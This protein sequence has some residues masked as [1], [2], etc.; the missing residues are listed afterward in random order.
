SERKKLT[1]T[2]Q[3]SYPRR[4][5]RTSDQ[6]PGLPRSKDFHLEKTTKSEGRNH[7][8]GN[9]LRVSGQGLQEVGSNW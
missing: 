5:P 7:H 9:R 8:R 1:G 6:D 4:A 2:F 3:P